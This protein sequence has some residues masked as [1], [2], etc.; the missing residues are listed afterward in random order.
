MKHSILCVNLFILLTAPAFAVTTVNS[1]FV[2]TNK[3]IEKA[4]I[5]SSDPSM[6]FVDNGGGLYKIH[7]NFSDANINMIKYGNQQLGLVRENSLIKIQMTGEKLGHKFTVN[8]KYANS[9]INVLANAII[10]FNTYIN[11]GCVIVTP[12]TTVGGNPVNFTINS[13][14]DVN[15]NCSAHTFDIGFPSVPTINVRGVSRDVYLDIGELNKNK[16]YRDAPPDVYTG[17][18]VYNG[19]V[20]KNRVGPGYPVVYN[21]NL[22]IIKNP[23]FER[24][25]LPAGDN[26]FDVKT[27]GND[28][29]GSLVIPYVINGHFTP[30]NKII[31]NV[32]SL[33]GFNLKDVDSKNSIPYSLSTTI[34]GQKTYS[35][36]TPGAGN[37]G[38]TIDNLTNENYALQGRFNA[39]FSID[40]SLVDVGDYTDTLTAIFE[41]AL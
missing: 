29:H 12:A 14:E 41:I 2:I 1:E 23:Y 40:K 24:V 32:T 6:E 20:I 9:E 17:K 27:T 16:Q 11:T 38:V 5:T 7:D 15:S 22:K 39:I 35:L 13:S 4:S 25:T 34:G 26:L 18:S 21:N 28:I 36:A 10:G 31:L 3:V 8:A 30:Y 33:N 19:E 37:G